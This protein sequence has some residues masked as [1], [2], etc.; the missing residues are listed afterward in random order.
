MAPNLK[1]LDKAAIDYLKS[2]LETADA[3]QTKRTLQD[4][5]KL[6]RQGFRVR[7]E[8]RSG[9]ENS[10]V[11][12]IYTAAHDPKIRRWSLN[13]LA[14]LGREAQ[15]REAILHVLKNY[16]HD[17][18]SVAA[19]IAA[20]Y[21]VSSKAS[22][23]LKSL[24]FDGQMIALAALQHKAP[25][26]L[27][28][29]SLPI[30]IN[31]ASPDLLKLAL[32]IVGLNKAPPHIFDPKYSNS[33]IVKVVGNHDDGVVAQYSIWAITENDDL[34][35]SDLGINI[36]DVEQQ[37][38]N[39]RAWLLQLVAMDSDSAY[40]Y[41]DLLRTAVAYEPAEV[42]AGL[43]LGLK[44]TYFDGIEPFVLDWLSNEMDAEVKGHLYD[45]I[46]IFAGKCS[47]YRDWALDSFKGEASGSVVRTRMKVTAHGLPLYQEFRKAEYEEQADLFGGMTIVAG[48]QNNFQNV[49]A[50]AFSVS[51]KAQ[52]TGTVNAHYNQQTVEKIQEELSKAERDL[53]AANVEPEVKADAL[54]QVQA[55]RLEP[56][57]D[58]ISKA[59]EVLGKVES[60]TNKAVGATTA[61]G[62]AAAAI[63]KAAGLL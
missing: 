57:P 54:K 15:C 60:L 3:G 12:L 8:H 26:E 22:E 17:P 39:V 25:H 33:E 55:A 1:L 47:A 51:G 50:G 44:K 16:E 13:A 31:T 62:A 58:R 63:G 7:P 30:N 10:I 36:S 28:L 14:Q 27:D 9:V 4:I 18:E 61:I 43:A 34:G 37:P 35:L 24:S 20:L 52:N 45:H 32:V 48:D 42:R 21:K 53:H 23:V 5:S 40:K 19:A 6:Y 56:T 2:Q 29:T 41:F 38:Q 59:I 46:I 11:G 49:N